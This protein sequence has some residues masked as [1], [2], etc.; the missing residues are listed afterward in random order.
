MILS[1]MM[2]FYTFHTLMHFDT[3]H[4]LMQF[5]T[6]LTTRRRRRCRRC[7]TVRVKHL[8]ASFVFSMYFCHHCNTSEH[9]QCFVLLCK[10][11]PCLQVVR[12]RSQPLLASQSKVQKR[13]L[14]RRKSRKKPH[15]GARFSHLH[16]QTVHFTLN[17]C[18]NGTDFLVKQNMQ[19]NRCYLAYIVSMHRESHQTKTSHNHLFKN[20]N[21]DVGNDISRVND[22]LKT[23]KTTTTPMS[24]AKANQSRQHKRRSFC[25]L[26]FV[27]RQLLLS[28][29]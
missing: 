28:S 13:R 6:V 3:F 5:D 10:T 12:I 21:L 27:F 9:F 16:Q 17:S 2:Q 29:T 15:G 4:T 7:C 22:N 11:P 25:L 18:C 1:H 24:T 8:I 20:V 14:H 23:T 19:D 26:L